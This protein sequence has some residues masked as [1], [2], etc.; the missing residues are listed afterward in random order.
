M[1]LS[2]SEI[3]GNLNVDPSTVQRI[4]LRF[5]ETGTVASELYPRG[6]VMLY[7]SLGKAYVGNS[8]KY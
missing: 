8:P 3:A 4:V 5:E 7:V 6:H 2:Y 1:E